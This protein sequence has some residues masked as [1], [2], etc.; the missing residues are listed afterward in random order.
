VPCAG[1]G[2]WEE[3]MSLLRW[4]FLPDRSA[5][6]RLN[7]RIPADR[8]GATDLRDWRNFEERMVDMWNNLMRADP[9]YECVIVGLK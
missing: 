5:F 3:A 2:N 7:A 1:V 9:R 6:P 4:L 8:W